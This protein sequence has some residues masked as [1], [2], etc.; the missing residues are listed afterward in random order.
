MV[1]RAGA[2]FV[3][4][5]FFRTS[6]RRQPYCV[7][8][9]QQANSCSVLASAAEV[10]LTHTTEKVHPPMHKSETYRVPSPSFFLLLPPVL[11]LLLLLHLLPPLPSFSSL[12]SSSLLLLLLQLFNPSISV[13]GFLSLQWMTILEVLPRSRAQ[14]RWGGLGSAA[15]KALISLQGKAL[16]SSGDSKLWALLQSPRHDKQEARTIRQ[17]RHIETSSTQHGMTARGEQSGKEQ[18]R[19]LTGILQIFYWSG[20][21]IMDKYGGGG[22]CGQVWQEC[23]AG[24]V[25]KEEAEI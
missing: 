17:R 3:G 9:V 1:R 15:G 23:R 5:N 2:E 19:G 21:H 13:R 12:S 14:V 10:A 16:S 24:R 6:P 7:E 22:G 4:I 18:E 25:W 8:E 20:K 11:I